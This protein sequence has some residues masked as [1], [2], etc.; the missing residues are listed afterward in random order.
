ML[1]EE[2]LSPTFLSYNTDRIENKENGE[3]T[4]RH[5]QQG[6]LISLVTK[7][8]RDTQRDGQTAS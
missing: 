8:R 6:D 4:Q 2:L 3:G 5:R 7:A 1:W